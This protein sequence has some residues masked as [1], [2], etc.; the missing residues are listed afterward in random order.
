MPANYISPGHSVTVLLPAA[1]KSGQGVRLGKLFGIADV[2]GAAGD[3]IPVS[4]DGVCLLPRPVGEVWPSIG[5]AIYY[6]EAA[7]LATTTPTGPAI[8]YNTWMASG[9][10]A[11]APVKLVPDLD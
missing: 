1:C 9:D 7:H 11:P 4:L 8:G 10:G 2:D 5:L 3:I 6:D